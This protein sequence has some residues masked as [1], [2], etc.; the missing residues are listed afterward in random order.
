MGSTSGFSFF[1]SAGLSGLWPLRQLAPLPGCH[2]SGSCG[3]SSL[4]RRGLA[5]A[6]PDNSQKQH[7]ERLRSPRPRRSRLINTYCYVTEPEPDAI[8]RL[9]RGELSLYHTPR[10]DLVE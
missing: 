8:E 6:F 7:H 4:R 2:R 3:P 1:Q 9:T 5:M 10:G